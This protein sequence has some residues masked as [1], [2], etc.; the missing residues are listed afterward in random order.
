MSHN[1]EKSHTK[2][3]RTGNGNR[4]PAN[5]KKEVINETKDRVNGAGVENCDFPEEKDC[6]QVGGSV[7]TASSTTEERKLVCTE[8]NTILDFLISNFFNFNFFF[9]GGGSYAYFGFFLS[10]K[11]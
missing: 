10:I 11:N 1:P 4:V 6:Y 7:I 3:T 2:T 9:L 8:E 5:V